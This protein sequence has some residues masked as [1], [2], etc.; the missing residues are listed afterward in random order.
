MKTKRTTEEIEAIALMTLRRCRDRRLLTNPNVDC[1]VKGYLLAQETFF[2]KK[3]TAKEMIEDML[4]DLRSRA[5]TIEEDMKARDGNF[6]DDE[7][8]ERRLIFDIISHVSASMKLYKKRIDL[9]G[10]ESV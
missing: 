6:T 9:I 1:F 5:D 3:P 8:E 2:E 10:D 4:T 7:K